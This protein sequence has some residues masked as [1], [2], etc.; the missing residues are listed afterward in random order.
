MNRFDKIKAM[1][2]GETADY[3]YKNVRSPCA[4]CAYEVDDCYCF[5]C[6]CVDG[7][8]LWLE[9]EDAD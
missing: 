6:Q 3:L 5:S 4:I 7:V 1:K 2:L 9:G 8:R